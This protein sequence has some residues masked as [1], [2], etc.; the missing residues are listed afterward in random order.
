MPQ[1]TKQS[2]FDKARKPSSNGSILSRAIAV[3]EIVDDYI[4]MVIYGVN[5]VGKTTLSC[6]FPKPLLLISYESGQAGGAKSVKKVEGVKYLK[7]TSTQDAL[8]LAMELADGGICDLPDPRYRGK[9]YKTHVHDTVTSLQDIVLK[10]L[11][12]LEYVMV[13]QNWGTVSQDTYRERSEKTREVLRPFREL[14]VHTVFCAQEKDHNPPREA[15]ANKLTRGLQLESFFAAD[16]GAA[17]VK[18]LHDSCD[19]IGRLYLDKEVKT[20]TNTVKVNNKP[21]TKTEEYETGKIVRRL[22]TML[23]PNYAA[24]FRSERPE[25]I[26]EFV[27]DP[28]FDKINELIQ[29]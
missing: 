9:T 21:V 15:G 13:Q 26:P 22:R 27:E 4:K 8:T 10:E 14:P 25:D 18:W 29:G 5:R 23:H 1:I 2:P 6:Q 16:L 11:L 20:R 3:D 19:Y 24:G 7:I 17:T 12:G 28:T